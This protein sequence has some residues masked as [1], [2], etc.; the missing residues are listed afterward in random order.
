[1]TTAQLGFAEILVYLLVF[2]RLSGMFLF[3]PIF[4]RTGV[5]VMTRMGL[6]FFL[7]VVLVPTLP[8]GTVEAVY[9]MNSFEFIAAIVA[10]LFIGLIFGFI[11]M[12]FY[13]MLNF[14]GDT[15]DTDFG[16]AMAKTFD[17]TSNIQVGFSSALLTTLFVLYLFATGGQYAL[18]RLFSSTFQTIGLG[19]ATMN[20]NVIVFVLQMFTQVFAL[21]I[22]LAAPFMVAEFIL[23]ASM[24]I[25][26]KFIPQI[27]VFVINFQ[28]RIILGMLMLYTFAPF[29]GE[30]IDNY[31][32]T[33][34]ATL[35]NA[36][37]LMLPA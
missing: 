11:F 27:T 28:L 8:A 4:S 18:I 17:P 34:F 9:S 26:M 16:I 19:T 31:I 20:T 2:V 7:A 33:M 24:G 35:V 22:R 10:E 13:R 6:I 37:E 36:A 25:L 5:P 21:A 14:V 3:N 23:Q 32:D 15:M 30:F 12:I 29:V 1:M